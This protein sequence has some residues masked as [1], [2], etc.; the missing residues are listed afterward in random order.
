M[1]PGEKFE[2]VLERLAK[3]EFGANI[4]SAKFVANINPSCVKPE[5]RGTFISMVYLCTMEEKTNLRGKWFPVNN[6]PEKTVW[7]HREIIIPCAI[8]AFV[9]EHGGV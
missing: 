9:A 2:D 1:R 7:S 6:L 5:I 4:S 8:G 3:R